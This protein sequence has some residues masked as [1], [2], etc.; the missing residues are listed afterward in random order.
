MDL[1]ILGVYNVVPFHDFISDV[2][3]H[4]FKVWYAVYVSNPFL[5]DT[6]LN[7]TKMSVIVSG[8]GP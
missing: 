3:P 4:L 2:E 7:R 6:T 8:S 1:L 5:V